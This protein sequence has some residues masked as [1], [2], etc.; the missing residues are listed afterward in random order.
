MRH[1]SRSGCTSSALTL[2]GTGS[3]P[4]NKV[5]QLKASAISATQGAQTTSSGE[6]LTAG[7]QLPIST[8]HHQ[9]QTV[10]KIKKPN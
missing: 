7:P 10:M 4:K 9:S 3:K 1:V 8:S 6:M 2:H 5:L